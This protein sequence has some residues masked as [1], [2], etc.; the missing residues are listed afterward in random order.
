MAFDVDQ[1]YALF[2]SEF[3]TRFD[4]AGSRK[5]E[6]M[7]KWPGAPKYATMGDG[8]TAN[9][10]P[11]QLVG[12]HGIALTG[13]QYVDTGIVDPFERTD[14]FSLFVVTSGIAGSCD[15]IGTADHANAVR[16]IILQLSLSDTNIFYAINTYAGNKYISVSAPNTN[17]KPVTSLCGTYNGSSLAAGSSIYKDGSLRTLTVAKDTLDA[18]I[19][20]GKSFLL[21]ARH[22]GA[23]K[24]AFLTGNIHFAAIFPWELTAQQVQ[25]LDRLCKTRINAA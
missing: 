18:T 4:V 1:R 6:N 24:S 25:Y 13:T 8:T 5:V 9:T 22:N 15:I 21:G 23:A 11:S 3:R 16:G 12:R 19:K 2:W 17:S 14:R 10:I 7:G 20:S